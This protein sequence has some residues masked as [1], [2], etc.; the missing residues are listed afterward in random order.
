MNGQ[1][2]TKQTLIQRL[3]DNQD[4]QSWDEF[5]GIYRPYIHT[6]IRNMNVPN[7]DIEDIA[8]QVLLKLWKHIQS[9][10]SDK[11]FRNWLSTITTNCVRDF[12]RK[13]LNDAKRIQKV[14]Q[15]TQ[16][17]CL[18]DIHVSEVEKIA[19]REWGIYMTGLAMKR[20]EKLFS[21]K[22]IEVFMMSLQGQNVAKIAL[23]TGLKENS[24]Y[25]LK[26]RVKERVSQEIKQL[27][28]ELE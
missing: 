19:E 8:Q 25:R 18:Q 16:L 15:E 28:L 6:I 11:P 23:K 14:A 10:S 5:I 2:K 26:N 4:E 3:K 20:I 27:K 1:Y 24:V 17:L 7:A 22:A 21:G 12:A 9:Y 13:Q